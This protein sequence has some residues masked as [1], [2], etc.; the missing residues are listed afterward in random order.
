MAKAKTKPKSRP[1][2]IFADATVFLKWFSSKSISSEQLFILCELKICELI[3][4]E[5]ILSEVLNKSQD[6][7]NE[8]V[9]IICENIEKVVSK[10]VDDDQDVLYMAEKND[11]DW[12]LTYSNNIITKQTD[13]F[14][15]G[16]PEEF[17]ATFPHRTT[18]TEIDDKCN[19]QYRRQIKK[20]VYITV[21]NQKGGCGKT[22]ITYNLAA[23]LAELKMKVLLIDMDPQNNLTDAC[24]IELEPEM[25]HITDFMMEKA[26][27]NDV[28]YPTQIANLH[29]IPSSLLLFSVENS[30]LTGGHV[31]PSTHLKHLLDKSAYINEYDFVVFDTGPS[32]GMLVINSLTIADRIIVPLQPHRFAIQGLQRIESVIRDIKD[33]VNPNIGEWKLLPSMVIKNRSEHNRVMAHVLEEYSDKILPYEVAQNSK[34]YES[35][36]FQTPLI[37]YPGSVKPA[38]TFR[39]LAI[40]IIKDFSVEDDVACSKN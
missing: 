26:Q 18:K 13:L 29:I 25:P 14:N 37:F 24:N 17:L 27:L 16:T 33:K 3:T 5:K 35:T 12:L 38:D 21:S 23:C 2:K 32:L 31:S 10:L 15:I 22:T 39:K 9:A 4:T 28:I 40:S 1:A 19:Q 11:V 34:V 8:S 6:Y 20:P 36:G 7:T 30:L